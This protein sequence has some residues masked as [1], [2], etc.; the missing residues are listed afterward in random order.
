MRD[1]RGKKLAPIHA[2]WLE[3]GIGSVQNI[4]KKKNHNQ[5][6]KCSYIFKWR[7]DPRCLVNLY[8]HNPPLNYIISKFSSYLRNIQIIEEQQP[9]HPKKNKNL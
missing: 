6:L 4:L 1:E 2:I 9:P 8:I 3:L 7:L 5:T